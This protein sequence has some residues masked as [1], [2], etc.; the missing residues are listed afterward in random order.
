[1]ST[2]N[3]PPILTENKISKPV[4]QSHYQPIRRKLSLD[5]EQVKK[6]NE[7]IH[8]SGEEILSAKNSLLDM[9]L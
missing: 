6:L 9:D 2:I 3:K 1:M 5:S 8:V 4:Q 7:D